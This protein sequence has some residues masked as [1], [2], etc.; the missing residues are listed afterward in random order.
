MIKINTPSA[1]IKPHPNARIR[2]AIRKKM[3]NKIQTTKRATKKA[4]A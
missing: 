1:S 3:R 2:M 4:A